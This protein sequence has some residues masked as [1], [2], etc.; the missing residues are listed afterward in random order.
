MKRIEDIDIKN[1]K[2]IIR[3]DFNVPLDK[4]LQILD[5]NRIKASLKTINYCLD[6]NCKI[7][8]LSH[9]G[10]VKEESDLKT[11]SLKGVAKRLSELLNKKVIFIPEARGNKVTE[12]ISNMKEKDIV[13]LENTR[14]MDLNGKLE[15]NCDPELSKYWASLG[16]VFINDAFGTIHRSHA[17]NVG[18]AKYIKESCLGFL[19]LNEIDNLMPII[20]N[21]KKPFTV[22]MGGAKVSDKIGVITNLLDKSTNILIGGAMA[23]TFLKAKGENIGKSLIDEESLEFA[24]ETLNKTDKI[25]LPI[26]HVVSNNMESNNFEI[27]EKL[28][29]NDIGL[30]IGPKTIELY[31]KYLE[32][33]KTIFWNGPM[34]YY[35]NK[36]FQNGTRKLCEI[37]SKLDTLSVVGG[38]DSAACVIEMGFKDKFSHVST[39]GGASLELIEGK[40]LPGLKAGE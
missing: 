22:I 14:F 23:Y 27:K 31:K 33:S 2:V 18:I 20:N 25:I 39:G 6:N 9:L 15:S 7:I 30:D 12:A 21:P 37:I 10:K 28:D 24:K 35:E 29:D 19:V 38:G 16:E 8:L 17:S 11:K 1:K 34:G 36:V 5:D 4:D 32:K 3:V 13:L 26:D 40:E